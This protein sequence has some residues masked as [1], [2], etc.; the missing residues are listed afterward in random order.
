MSDERKKCLQAFADFLRSTSSG[1][2]F[3][4]PMLLKKSAESE[5]N[6]ND[7]YLPP[8]EVL[9]GLG[10]DVMVR[11]LICLKFIKVN[12][13]K[14]HINKG[15]WDA[16]KNEY[17]LGNLLELEGKALKGK[18]R[19]WY[20]KLGSNL[21]ERAEHCL[22]SADS[23]KVRIKRRLGNPKEF[24]NALLELIAS[25]WDINEMETWIVD[26]VED[27]DDGNPDT[28]ASPALTRS[29][30]GVTNSTVSPQVLANPELNRTMGR[31]ASSFLRNGEKAN[32]DEYPF[33]YEF[34]VPID[35]DDTL[36][37]IYRDLQK[38]LG[39]NSNDNALLPG[40][41]LYEQKNGTP[42]LMVQISKAGSRS[43]QDKF[44]STVSSAM[45]WAT[46]DVVNEE[47][48]VETVKAI[49]GN[50]AERFS[51]L[52]VEVGTD[53]QLCMPFKKMDAATA[54][55]M[56]EEANVNTTGM[57][58]IARY[59]RWL[60]GYSIL[61]TQVQ[62]R[63]V[64]EQFFRATTF[65][66]VIDGKNIHYWYKDVDEVLKHMVKHASA[67]ED[68][69]DIESMDMSL[70]G[71]HGKGA[72]T[73]MA[74]LA[75]RYK[76]ESKI[77]SKYLAMQIG[78]I[79]SAAD[80][81]EI[82]KPLV[83]RLEAGLLR[84]K[85]DENGDVRFVIHEDPD[86]NNELSFNP[87]TGAVAAGADLPLVCDSKIR[88]FIAGDMKF[89]F[90]M[91]GR[92]GFSGSY[93][94]W[95]KLSKAE[96]SICHNLG[97][98]EEG[99]AWTIQDLFNVN[100]AAQLNYHDNNGDG[101]MTGVKEYPFWDFIPINRYLF[102]LLHDLL[103]LGN[104]IVDF[105]WNYIDERWETQSAEVK[106]SYDLC[107]VAEIGLNKA[108]QDVQ[109]WHDTDGF[110]LE[111]MMVESKQLTQALLQR[112]LTVDEKKELGE[113]RAKMEK[114]KKELRQ[115]RDIL[116]AKVKECGRLHREFKRGEKAMRK[117]HGRSGKRLRAEIED[118]IL[119]PLGIDSAAYHGGDLAGN[120][121]RRLMEH[122][123]AVAIGLNKKLK[124]YKVVHRD[125]EIDEFT[126]SVK[127]VL[128]LLDGIYSLLLTKYGEVTPE[129]VNNLNELLELLRLQWVKMQLP[130]T[131]KFHCLLRHAVGQL[132]ETDGGL[133]DLGEDGIERNHQ[134]RWKDSRRMTGIKD[135]KLRTNSQ[136]KMQH[137]RQMKEIKE[138]QATVKEDSKRNMK[139]SRSLADE[140]AAKEKGEREEKRAKAATEARESDTV[141]QQTARQRNLADLKS[142][143]S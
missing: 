6:S 5:V 99:G 98:D 131:P 77:E 104:N 62:V 122:A 73:Y 140:N 111:A 137:I 48:E 134:E 28:A 10:P 78:Q 67:F 37:G 132:Q 138:I 33:L 130:M 30:A 16:F 117:K 40:S 94:L 112:G 11:G 21:N 36:Y 74:L 141:V 12:K 88:L 35:N 34:G 18:P 1:W 66:E 54:V 107:L 45:A 136:T 85:P 124:L 129:I 17:Q 44:V 79:D 118:D 24:T 64:G 7:E 128:L 19:Q 101:T 109:K 70:G 80:S 42:G 15:P 100:A 106:D 120:A 119:K 105:I 53:Q 32:Q 60:F 91:A 47:A 115:A 93:C 108:R 68:I 57:R 90:T 56:A 126:S 97:N 38:R 135:F 69:K 41:F 22:Q 103:G 133:G 92:D 61:P 125:N 114:E 82:L 75:I 39:V 95:C 139:R 29:P 76:K 2:W 4:V 71:D 25:D 26:E 96:W 81:A 102:P 63:A 3:R 65:E 14:C 46:S 121:V 142:K 123:E 116:K 84:M 20:V 49:V 143:E 83:K 55:S 87:D 72:F 52:Y 59:L 86:G 31:G 27:E 50:A 13:N 110:T 89:E 127:V 58:V 51:E 43:G 9:F 8:M 23:E 113:E